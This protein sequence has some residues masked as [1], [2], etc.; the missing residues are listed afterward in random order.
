M[1]STHPHLLAPRI[2][3]YLSTH[4]HWYRQGRSTVCPCCTRP[5]SSHNCFTDPCKMLP[6]LIS[7]FQ[8]TLTWLPVPFRTQHSL[9]TDTGFV[10]GWK[11]N[12][13]I[14]PSVRGGIREYRF[15]SK[16]S[17]VK[18]KWIQDFKRDAS[19][20]ITSVSGGVFCQTERLV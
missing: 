10:A 17:A 12:S 20:G 8:I 5:R 3:G 7:L 6:A 18:E 19:S 14:G 9:K 16:T 15:Y 4:T 11:S 2:P 1:T 13:R